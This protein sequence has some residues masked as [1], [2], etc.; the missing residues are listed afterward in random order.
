MSRFTIIDCEQ[1]TPEWFAARAGRLTGSA[2]ADMMRKVKSGDWSTSRKHLRMR[3]GLERITGQPQESAFTTA[4]V[5]H[6]I[7][8]EPFA[9]VRYEAEAGCILEPLGFLSM[10]PIMAGCSLDS[11]IHG[12][13]GIVEIK[14]PESATHYEYLKTRQIPSDYRWQCIHN[15]WVTGAEYCDFISFD[16]RFPDDLQYL[17]VRL[18]R[19]E[20]EI[21]AY[22]AEVNRFLA[23]VA[24]EVSDINKLRKAA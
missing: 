12:R 20:S 6:G 7:E 3:L 17:C 18:E 10:G 2:A 24:V 8:K 22:E 11:F 9:S 15:L 14:C 16:D 5:A 13:R 19:K 1:R 4:A 21:E 23:E